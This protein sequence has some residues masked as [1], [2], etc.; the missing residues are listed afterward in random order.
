MKYRYVALVMALFLVL[1]LAGCKPKPAQQAPGS[2]EPITSTVTSQ[3]AT[4]TSTTQASAPA[5]STPVS[6]KPPVTSAGSANL[7]QLNAAALPQAGFSGLLE[8]MQSHGTSVQAYGDLKSDTAYLKA[9]ADLESVLD[10]YK[11]DISVVAYSIDGTKALS[12]NTEKAMFCACTVKAAYTL[13]C[14]RQMEQGKGSLTTKMAYK[15]EHYESGTGNMQYSSFGTQFTMDTI[16]RKSM[17][18][19]DNVGYRMSIDYFGRESYNQWITDLGCPT[20]TIKPTVWS[21]KAKSTDLAKVWG[22]IYN[23]FKTDSQYARFLYEICTNTADNYGTAA[24]KNVD[25]SHKQGHNNTSDWPAYSDAGIV[26]KGNTPYVYVIL[27]NAPGPSS[28]NTKTMAS[29]IGIIDGQLF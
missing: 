8:Q 21:L 27:T 19:S 6:S 17:G 22:Q 14:C 26:W 28:Y 15:K 10:D 9:L 13:Y 11:Y 25:I 12:Y 24:L 2:S 7:P 16:L 3:P 20:L 4:S 1:P 29:I 18:I 23:Y 5:T